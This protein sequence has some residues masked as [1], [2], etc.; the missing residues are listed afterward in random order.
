MKDRQQNWRRPGNTAVSEADHYR[1]Q[2]LTDPKIKTSKHEKLSL[3]H[4]TVSYI[5]KL[6]FVCCL[7][8]GHM[9]LG[10]K[11]FLKFCTF[12]D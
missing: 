4:N 7:R 10:C 2:N 5:C 8:S 3:F 6:T 9:H 11:I 1:N 12:A